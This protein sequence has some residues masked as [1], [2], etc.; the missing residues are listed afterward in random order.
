[1][2][3][4]ASD[5]F[6]ISPGVAVLESVDRILLL[7]LNY[8]EAAQAPVVL[9]NESGEIWKLAVNG[10]H[11]GGIL[12]TLAQQYNTT[13]R[14]ILSDVTATIGLLLTHGFLRRAN[15]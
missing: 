11:F 6:E 3:L 2:T 15:A 1:M 14:M 7:N 12:E 8:R 5:S 10:L 4:N 13:S 9:Q